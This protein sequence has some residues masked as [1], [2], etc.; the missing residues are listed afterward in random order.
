PFVNRNHF[1]MWIAMALPLAFGYIAAREGAHASRIHR[2][3]R[4]SSLVDF[5]A[6]RTGWIIMAAGSML[7]ALLLSLSRAGALAL[8]IS[9]M[10]AI[11]LVRRRLDSN[12]RSWLMGSVLFA[13]F[14]AAGWADA[15][16]IRER[17]TGT[18]A[19][20]ANR[21][22]I[23]RDTGPIVGDFWLTGTGAGTYRLAMLVYQRADRSVVFNQAHN[24]Y[25]QAAAEGGVLLLVPVAL[26]LAAFVRTAARQLA[27]DRSAAWGLRAS[28]ACGLGAAAL[29]SICETGLVMPANAALAAVLAA[30]VV[31]ERCADSVTEAPARR[32]PHGRSSSQRREPV[33]R[34]YT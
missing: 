16:A 20:L 28:A 17:L 7:L 13:S 2:R 4:R 21:F 31:H 34:R 25:L 5:A 12:Q 8:G 19:A 3:S 23:W 30:V 15:P 10:A 6:S 27:S 11:V 26:A 1:A 18:P 14:M 29:H 24:H 22:A 9:A 33:R 32:F